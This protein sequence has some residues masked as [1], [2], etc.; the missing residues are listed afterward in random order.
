MNTLGARAAAMG[1]DE[2]GSPK[3]AASAAST[4][5]TCI[6]PAFAWNHGDIQPEIANT[7]LGFVGP[8]VR[9]LGQDADVWTDHTDVRP[10]LLV[11]LGLSTS[12]DNDGRAITEVLDGTV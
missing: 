6:N 10:T 3:I 12:Y 8:G 11:A 4:C 2:A 9:N 5:E 1:S 7:W